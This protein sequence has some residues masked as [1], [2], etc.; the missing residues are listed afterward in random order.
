MFLRNVQTFE[1]IDNLRKGHI[2]DLGCMR[3]WS[4]FVYCLHTYINVSNVFDTYMYV[5]ISTI[6][7]NCLRKMHLNFE[8][9]AEN[10]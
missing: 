6:L 2:L 8:V 5:H 9:R 4:M 1:S 3:F 7:S 10:D